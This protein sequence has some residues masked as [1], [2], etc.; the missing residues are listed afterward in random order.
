MNRLMKK[1]L[2][3]AILP[4]AVMALLT[5][6]LTSLLIGRFA[7]EETYAQLERE[8]A[9]VYEAIQESRGIPGQL[10]VLVFQNGQRIEFERGGRMHRMMPINLDPNDLAIQDEVGVNGTRFLT[11]LK[12]EGDIQIVTYSPVP[13]SNPQFQQIYLILAGGFILALLVA[14]AV[15]YWMSRRLTQPLV[16]LKQA[17]ASIMEGRHDI[18][19]PS[20]TN[21]EIG[22]LTV[23]IGQMNTSLQEKEALQKSFIS[24]V[25]HD[26]RTPLAIVRNEAELL[27]LGV[28]HETEMATTGKSITEEVDRIDRLVNQMLEYSK[29]SAGSIPLEMESIQLDELVRRLTPRMSELFRQKDVTLDLRLETVSIQADRLAM[30]RVLSNF[31]SN[32]YEASPVGGRITITL[33]PKRL[34]VTDEGNGVDPSIQHAI[35]DMYVK[36]DRSNGHGLGLA[37]TKLL[38]DAQ[39]LSY[40]VDSD[41]GATFWIEWT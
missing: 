32:A 9:I 23:T 7:E 8:A 4:L 19:L 21:D 17:T 20:V 36:G 22:D 34:E 11:Y 13:F 30:E 38:L 41:K 25:T 18:S 37:I 2:W 10:D 12:E 5:F 14:I 16:E 1:L 15:T 35:W 3:T 40:G 28:V 39:G 31:I 24:G 6:G 33:T 27:E 26:V 29:L